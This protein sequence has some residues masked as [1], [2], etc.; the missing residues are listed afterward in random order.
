M[1]LYFLFESLSF[2]LNTFK[3]YLDWV[4]YTFMISANIPQVNKRQEVVRKSIISI[5]GYKI[6]I[7]KILFILLKN[8]DI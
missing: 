4:L 5:Y 3:K 1:H 2:V 7:N 6:K 8:P